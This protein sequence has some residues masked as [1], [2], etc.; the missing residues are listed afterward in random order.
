MS[1]FWHLKEKV[2]SNFFFRTTLQYPLELLR[3]MMMMMMMQAHQQQK[4]QTQ[5]LKKA[6]HA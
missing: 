3:T 6:V 4:E 2:K 1:Y 5:R